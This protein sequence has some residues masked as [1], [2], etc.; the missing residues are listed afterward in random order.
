MRRDLQNHMS[1][2]YIVLGVIV[3]L[4][5]YFIVKYNGFVILKTR[6]QEA[7]ADIDVQRYV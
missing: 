2:L 6:T 1:I 4:V 5:L 7:W 3:A